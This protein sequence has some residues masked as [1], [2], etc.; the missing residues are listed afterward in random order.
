MTMRVGIIGC[1]LMGRRHADGY[2]TALAS[3]AVCCDANLESAQRLAN[4]LDADV[5]DDWET[6]IRDDTLDAV[7]ICTPHYLH[8]PQVLAAVNAGKHVLLEKPM[9]LDLREA[10]QMVAAADVA[11]VVLM[12]AQNQRYLAEHA[13][14]KQLLNDGIIG[15]VFGVRVDANQMLSRI[16]P[17][18][19][20][21]F[22]KAKTGG[23]VI[24]TTGIHK[25][26]LLRYLVG[27][28]KRVAA[29]HRLSGLNP[30]MD[31]DD[32]AAVSLEFENGAVGEAFFTFA[33][34]R[35]PIPSATHEMT[36]LYGTAGVLQNVPEWQVYST[37]FPDYADE[38]TS[39]NLP[40]ADYLQTFRNEIQHFIDCINTGTEPLSSG[41]DNLKTIAVI[42]AIY[43]SAASGQV[44][45]VETV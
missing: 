23:G 29:F 43:E 40:K 19:H 20:W 34:H 39:L 12:I 21:L 1:G 15:D 2:R 7:S 6:V 11:G 8:L 22:S 28:I 24:R 5:S 27:E 16:Y 37:A 26:D 33:A 14:I 44:I 42:D 38:F 45:E 3:V 18:G 41:R 31:S 13:V 36:I 17:E 9:A 4:D 25:I 32:V 10:R 30:G 35:L